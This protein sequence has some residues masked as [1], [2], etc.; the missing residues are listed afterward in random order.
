MYDA[1]A[2]CYND[3]KPVPLPA[4]CELTDAIDT[5]SHRCL[6]KGG[7]FSAYDS[8]RISTRLQI[9]ETS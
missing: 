3:L 9:Q 8:R 1:E 4:R 6:T 7:D 5:G 2:G